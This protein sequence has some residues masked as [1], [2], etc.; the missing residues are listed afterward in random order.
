MPIERCVDRLVL[1]QA[2]FRKL[3]CSQSSPPAD[4]RLNQTSDS[5]LVRYSKLHCLEYSSRYNADDGN[6]S[7]RCSDLA[8]SW[9]HLVGQCS[10]HNHDV[11]LS[12]TSSEDDAEAVHVVTGRRHVH[13]LHG[14]AGQ[15]KGHRPQRALRGKQGRVSTTEHLQGSVRKTNSESS[16]LKKNR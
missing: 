4:T 5:E 7:R 6:K 1:I 3:Y 8:Q 14:A 16:I 15:A 2:E 10:S 12:G 9:R 13:H 11:S